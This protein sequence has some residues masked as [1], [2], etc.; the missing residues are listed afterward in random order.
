MPS[1]APTVWRERLRLCKPLADRD[2]LEAVDW[3]PDD[4][5]DPRYCNYVRE[6]IAEGRRHVD[7]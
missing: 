5:A 1:P 6:D 7:A 3:E 2:D 4:P